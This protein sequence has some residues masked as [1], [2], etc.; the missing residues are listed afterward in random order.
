V[1]ARVHIGTSGWHYAHWKGRFYPPDLPAS[2]HLAYYAEHFDVVELN[3]TFY[4]LPAESAVLGWKNGSP[5]HFLFAVKGSRFLTH[6]KKLKDAETGLERFFSRV[7]LLGSKLGWVLFQL[8][9][10]W[11]CDRGR[12]RSFLEAL[13]RRHRYAFEFRDASWNNA[14]ISRLLERFGAAYCIFDLA[15]F[16]SPLTLTANFT[17]IRLHGPGGRY[18]GSYDDSAL[19][20]WNERIAEWNLREA[21]VFFDNDQAAY[22]VDNALRLRKL[23]GW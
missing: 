4:R 22:A 21:Y 7:D 23:G 11:S 2:R 16:Q 19:R 13:P 14:E 6:M 5:A 8:P 15:G 9:P 20:L 10:N 17:Y 1:T 18:Q 12:L 3:N